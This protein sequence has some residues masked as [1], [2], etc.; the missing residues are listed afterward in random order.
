MKVYRISH[1]KWSKKLSASGFPA[2]WNSKGKFVIYAASSRALACLENVVHRSGE[3]LNENFK[4]MVIEIP[5]NVK[6]KEIKKED[7]PGDWFTFE[8]YFDC[9]L[10][11]DSW[12]DEQKYA[13]L[14]VPSSIIV[15]ECNYVININHKNFKRIKLVA[16]ENFNFDPRIKGGLLE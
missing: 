14:K 5:S 13:V 1:L 12:V 3:G 4:V 9:Q 11:G 7:L 6:I 8:S 15:N 16:V 10:I 2:R